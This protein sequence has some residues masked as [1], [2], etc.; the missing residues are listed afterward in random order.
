M[1]YED[2]FAT[3]PADDEA[4]AEVKVIK[5]PSVQEGADA[6]IV[7]TFKEGSGFDATWNVVHAANAAEAKS[8]LLD[9]EYKE[10]LELQKKAASFFRGG[11]ASASAR[12]AAPAGAT[13]PPAW[14]PPKPYDDFVY[15]TGV[16]KAGKVWHAWMAPERGDDRPA[17]WFYPPN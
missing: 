15:K 2:P 6:K 11:A 9:P 8:I 13:Q 10:L 14:A 4:Q 1:S 7:M 3:A 17:K 5:T 12:P 16:S